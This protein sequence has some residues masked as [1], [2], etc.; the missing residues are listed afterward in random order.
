MFV[1]NAP[2]CLNPK[3]GGWGQPPIGEDK[4]DSYPRIAREKLVEDFS[5]DFVKWNG[6]CHL[7][8][9]VNRPKPGFGAISSDEFAVRGIKNYSGRFYGECREKYFLV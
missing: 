9:C 2:I 4:R 6:E 5:V 7:L 8:R 1:N 3:L